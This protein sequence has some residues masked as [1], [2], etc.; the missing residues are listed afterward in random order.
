MF[1]FSFSSSHISDDN[2][3]D[4]HSSEDNPDVSHVRIAQIFTEKFKKTINRRSIHDWLK[5]KKKISESLTINSKTKNC[6][7]E[8]TY[9]D[10]DIR[11][12]RWIEELEAKGGF[13]TEKL[14]KEQALIIGQEL[15]LSTFKASSG[16]LEKF[17]NRKNISFRSIS[18][19]A[20]NA[21]IE[22]Y[23]D[24]YKNVGDLML[25]YDDKDIF[26]ADET[27]LFYKLMPSKSLVQ[28]VRRGIK[29]YKE[30][31]TLLLCCNKNGTEKLSPLIIGKFKS[32][33]AL[34]DF[35]YKSFCNYMHNDSAWMNKSDF[36]KWLSELN[37]QMHKQKRKILLLIDNCPSHNLSFTPTNIEIAYLP[38]NSTFISQPL[39]MGIIKSF[40]VK[41][42]HYQM[43]NILMR[44]KEVPR[45]DQLYK[46]LTIKDAILFTHWAWRDVSQETMK[47]CWKKAGYNCVD[48]NTEITFF[49][50]N[51]NK[52][53]VDECCSM[54]RSIN[55]NDP[56][57]IKD[58]LDLEI[59]KNEIIVSELNST[60]IHQK[61]LENESNNVTNSIFGLDQFDLLFGEQDIL[62]N[63]VNETDT[64]TLQ[65]T[66]VNYDKVRNY[67]LNDILN[68]EYT[69]QN[70]I[71]SSIRIIENFLF[72]KKANSGYK[73]ITD[74][75]K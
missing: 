59:D 53:I 57:D 33:R 51:N 60:T 31:L 9:E 32:P 22:D 13:Y 65:E 70:E 44:M 68:E 74:Y 16:W 6:P 56:L 1:C 73:K 64:D 10:V 48:N 49:E 2:G 15:N 71:L 28:V 12:S 21:K 72:K 7:R 50:E 8:K 58:M 46:R 42:Y 23:S 62:D 35:N 25:K 29:K 37:D 75:F 3:A 52:Q 38:K 5:N 69:K 17:K 4:I 41:F 40:K 47:N 26:N 36:N 55:Q 54:F 11:L 34:K 18:G 39:D 30:R 14:L 61:T 45:V 19:E 20:G 27:S 63:E 66:I 24:F 67:I 43:R